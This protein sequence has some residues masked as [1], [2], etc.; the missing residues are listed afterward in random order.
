MQKWEYTTL[1]N[2]V[3]DKLKWKWDDN[4]KTTKEQSVNSRLD[5]MGRQ[6]W[7]LVNISTYQSN[8][9]TSMYYFYFKRPI[10]E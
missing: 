5:E 1:S 6:G 7:E 10:K 2:T 8:G 4:G 9:Y 3:L